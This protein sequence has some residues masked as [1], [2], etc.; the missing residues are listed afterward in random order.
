MTDL[1]LVSKE[2]CP[3]CERPKADARLHSI[4]GL[5]AEDL[6][7]LVRTG[8][9]AGCRCAECN[10]PIATV[11]GAVHA[12]P[13]RPRKTSAGKKAPRL[14]VFGPKPDPRRR[15][16]LR[17]PTR[18]MKLKYLLEE[19]R[20][21]SAGGVAFNEVYVKT[22]LP[23]RLAETLQEIDIAENI[24]VSRPR[25]RGQLTDEK[26]LEI[27]AGHNT[28]RRALDVALNAQRKEAELTSEACAMDRDACERAVTLF[29]NG[30]PI[31]VAVAAMEAVLARPQPWTHRR[32]RANVPI[33]HYPVP[34]FIPCSRQVIMEPTYTE[35]PTLTVPLDGGPVWHLLRGDTADSVYVVQAGVTTEFSLLGACLGRFTTHASVK[36]PSQYLTIGAAYAAYD[37]NDRVH[38]FRHS[39]GDGVDRKAILWSIWPMPVEDYK[40]AVFAFSSNAEVA[41]VRYPSQNIIRRFWRGNKYY[42]EKPM[43]IPQDV[44]AG[45]SLPAEA[46]LR[47]R[48][49][50]DVPSVTAVAEE[51]SP[52][53]DVIAHWTFDLETGALLQVR[54]CNPVCRG[55][56]PNN[57]AAMLPTRR[58]LSTTKGSC[59]DDRQ[60]DVQHKV[61]VL[62]K[63]FAGR[64]ASS[65]PRGTTWE[66]LA[67]VGT[68][69][70]VVGKNTVGNYALHIWS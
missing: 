69:I 31:R 19:R 65:L 32:E 12:I 20:D 11:I 57:L 24:A 8:Q 42:W 9:A 47:L 38:V 63:P 18:Y 53:G 7:M 35:W 30:Y 64:Q 48:F 41:I 54:G 51:S 23:E 17:E 58:F 22:R 6:D 56:E 60:F 25:A 36:E 61:Y 5:C 2:P 28:A 62:H 50:V 33:D 66:N 27:V 70:V 13:F 43:T 10:E 29:K 44:R 4:C 3:M 15:P 40:E 45:H 16:P 26:H 1:D 21:H 37:G 14:K 67:T 46:G 52:A 34:V 68:S 59:G 39:L 55:R 49:L